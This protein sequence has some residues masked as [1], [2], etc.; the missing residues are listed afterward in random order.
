MNLNIPVVKKMNW[1]SSETRWMKKLKQLKAAAVKNKEKRRIRSSLQSKTY[2]YKIQD[3][4]LVMNCFR[5]QGTPI[6]HFSP[7][8]TKEKKEDSERKKKKKKNILTTTWKQKLVRLAMLC[9]YKPLYNRPYRK[10]SF[11]NEDVLH[12]LVFNWREITSLNIFLT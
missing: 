4:H 2:T 6:S 8:T 9:I 5:L 11:F 10:L 7:L 12:T 1:K 3:I